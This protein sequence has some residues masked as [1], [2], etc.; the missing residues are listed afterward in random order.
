MGGVRLIVEPTTPTAEDGGHH[1]R[2]ETK[3]L[4]GEP[5]HA[6]RDAVDLPAGTNSQAAE[7]LTVLLLR[8]GVRQIDGEHLPQEANLLVDLLLLLEERELVLNGAQDELG[9]DFGRAL[10]PGLD[11]VVQVAEFD[12]QLAERQALTEGA[13]VTAGFREGQLFIGNPLQLVVQA[14]DEALGA[15]VRTSLFRCFDR[16]DG[17]RGTKKATCMALDK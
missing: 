13:H 11:E 2:R 5:D 7:L 10:A 8:E 12:R 15:H 17:Q 9:R 4:E 14:A 16:K 3:V 1:P 6:L